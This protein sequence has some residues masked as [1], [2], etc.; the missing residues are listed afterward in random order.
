MANFRLPHFFSL[1]L[2]III[3][4][5]EEHVFVIAGSR[6]EML[7]SVTVINWG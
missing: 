3:V 6:L 5:T 1:S 4:S 7:K 2:F